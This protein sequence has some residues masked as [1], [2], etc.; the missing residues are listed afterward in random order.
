MKFTVLTHADMNVIFIYR[1]SNKVDKYV[2]KNNQISNG[3]E[4]IFAKS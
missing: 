4:I 1:Y 2:S 3:F